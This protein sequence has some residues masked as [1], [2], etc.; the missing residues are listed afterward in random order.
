MREPQNLQELKEWID[1]CPERCCACTKGEGSETMTA[2]GTLFDISECQAE[3]WTIP[4]NLKRIGMLEWTRQNAERLA[5]EFVVEKPNFSFLVGELYEDYLRN[6][7][8]PIE[9]IRLWVE[10]KYHEAM[11]HV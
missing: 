3:P 11:Q 8:Y 7:I 1:R 4:P 2:Q 10:K 6:G 9:S 5:D